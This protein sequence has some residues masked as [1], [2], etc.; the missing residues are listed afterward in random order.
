MVCKLPGIS[1]SLMKELLLHVSH[2][3]ADTI[4]RW[5]HHLDAGPTADS[6][7]PMMKPKQPS[8]GFQNRFRTILLRS[9]I[10][11]SIFGG[12]PPLCL[13]A[14]GILQ[15]QVGCLLPS[16]ALIQSDEF[17]TQVPL[18]PRRF[19]GHWDILGQC[20]WHRFDCFFIRGK[21]AAVGNTSSYQ[22]DGAN[23]SQMQKI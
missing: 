18:A 2:P 8:I 16:I 17:I 3:T 5:L 9:T 20:A 19:G 7:G 15:C 13:T 22:R 11:S 4:K 1:S 6:I 21:I 14:F 12:H 23:F 10:C